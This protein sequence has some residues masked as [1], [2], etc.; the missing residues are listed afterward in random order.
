MKSLI[1]QAAEGCEICQSDVCECPCTYGC[2]EGYYMGS[3]TPGFDF[4][5]DD[6]DEI[7]PCPSCRGTNL[8]KK[9]VLW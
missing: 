5:N 4:I 6:E 1:E 2:D 3:E 9:R 7:Y 8:E